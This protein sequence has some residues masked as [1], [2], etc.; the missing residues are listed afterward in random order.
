MSVPVGKVPL[1]VF[2]RVFDDG[3][4]LFAAVGRPEPRGGW[5]A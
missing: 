5:A 4:S 3:C 2:D 1:P